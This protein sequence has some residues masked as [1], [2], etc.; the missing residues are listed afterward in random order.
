VDGWEIQL[1]PVFLFG[2]KHPMISRFSMVFYGFSM[3][4]DHPFGGKNRISQLPQ[5][6]QVNDDGHGVGARTD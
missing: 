5:M 2:G 3:V 4:F 6:S 1:S